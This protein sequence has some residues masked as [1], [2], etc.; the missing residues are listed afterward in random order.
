M[1]KVRPKTS[2]VKQVE[3]ESVM[4]G[5]CVREDTTCQS[6]NSSSIPTHT[7]WVGVLLELILPANLTG[8]LAVVI[9]PLS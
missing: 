1:S 7:W 2:W 4:F 5:I 8:L 3:E 6:I 9:L